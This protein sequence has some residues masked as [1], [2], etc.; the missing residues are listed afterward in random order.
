[1]ELN[2]IELVTDPGVY[3]P[4]EDTY[5][6]LDAIELGPTDSFLEIGCGSGLLSVAAAK[7]AETVVATDVSLKAVRNTQE[8]LIR[9][10]LEHRCAVLQSDL[11]SAIDPDSEFS[12]IAFNPPYLPKDEYMTDMDG[13][14]VGGMVGVEMTERFLREIPPYLQNHASVYVVVSSL[15]DVDRVEAAMLRIGLHVEKLASKKLFFE[16]LQVLRGTL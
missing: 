15:A 13:A 11:L 2:E 1:V 4:S 9:N 6:L 5:L 8:N 10:S 12:V 7:T 16:T 3:Q 14:L